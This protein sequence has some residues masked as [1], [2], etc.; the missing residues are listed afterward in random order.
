MYVKARASLVFHE[1]A[2]Q[3]NEQDTREGRRGSIEADKD[4][5]PC[6]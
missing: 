1:I 4:R 2:V 3:T 6:S 5:S